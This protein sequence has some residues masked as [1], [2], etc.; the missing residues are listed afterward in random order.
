MPREIVTPRLVG[1]PPRAGDVGAMLAIYGSPVVAERL[2]PDGL[3]RTE[4]DLEAAVEADIA[5]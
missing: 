3:P 1:R 5:H 2:Y 4:A